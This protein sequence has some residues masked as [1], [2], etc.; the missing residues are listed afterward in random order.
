MVVLCTG[1]NCLIYNFE[2]SKNEMVCFRIDIDM[3]IEYFL[4]FIRVIDYK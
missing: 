2:D 3:L 4:S 1:N